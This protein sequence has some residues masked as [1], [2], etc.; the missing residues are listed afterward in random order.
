M[1]FEKEFSSLPVLFS[2]PV[3]TRPLAVTAIA[4]MLLSCNAVD[5]LAQFQLRVGNGQSRIVAGQGGRGVIGHFDQSDGFHGVGID[6]SGNIQFYSGS[7]ANRSGGQSVGTGGHAGSG[8]GVSLRRGGIVV[9]P[10][11]N[12]FIIGTGDSQISIGSGGNVGVVVTNP[13]MNQPVPVRPCPRR[14]CPPAFTPPPNYGTPVDRFPA[15][16][17]G[18]GG[19]VIDVGMD[20]Q[21][22]VTRIQSLMRRGNTEAAAVIAA[23]LADQYADQADV[24]VAYSMTRFARHEFEDSAAAMYDALSIKNAWSW[25][26]A[27]L[28]F[29]TQ[30]AYLASLRELQKTAKEFPE[31]AS[32]RFLLS[33]HYVMLNAIDQAR[34]SLELTNRLIPGDKVVTALQNQLPPVPGETK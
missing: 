16:E 28:Y 8:G 31:S 13:A 1:L 7:P 23:A 21:P 22:G 27:R 10:G 6:G 5:A 18:P 15:V 25:S 3:F 33:S 29:A 17:V 30:E 9:G 14:T 2:A 11:K 32:L 20:P 4:L 26:E 34:D 24:L 12:G 19:V